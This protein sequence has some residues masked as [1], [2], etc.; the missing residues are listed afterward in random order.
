MNTPRC[1]CSTLLEH[2]PELGFKPD[3][4]D[5]DTDPAT[6]Y[7]REFGAFTVRVRVAEYVT[8]RWVLNSEGGRDRVEPEGGEDYYYV[9]PSVIVDLPH[10]CDE[11]EVAYSTGQEDAVSQLA[12]FRDHA[13]DAL[14]YVRALNLN[15]PHPVGEVAR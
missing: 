6:M 7:I 14:G 1:D 10:Q 3:R 5:D 15:L 2:L 11:W 8:A 9:S 12:E 13:T 4:D